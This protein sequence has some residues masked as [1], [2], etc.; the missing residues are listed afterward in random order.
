MIKC[1]NE[2]WETD[3][4]LPIPPEIFCA[5]GFKKTQYIHFAH[6]RPSNYTVLK[7]VFF[8]KAERKVHAFK[9]RR[10][11]LRKRWETYRFFSRWWCSIPSWRLRPVIAIGWTWVRQESLRNWRALGDPQ[12]G[13]MKSKLIYLCN[14]E[15]PGEKG[16]SLSWPV[17]GSLDADHTGVL[18]DWCRSPPGKTEK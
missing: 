8:F 12:T 5:H 11:H 4:E 6:S 14:W 15:W 17:N 7:K 10:V 16:I 1:Q 9:G 18:T 2:I 13:R 3:R